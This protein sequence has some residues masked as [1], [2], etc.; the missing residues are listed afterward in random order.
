MLVNSDASFRVGREF[1]DPP[2]GC[3]LPLNAASERFANG[4]QMDRERG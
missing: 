4:H 3:S 2:S 1:R